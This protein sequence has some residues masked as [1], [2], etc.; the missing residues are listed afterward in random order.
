MRGDAAEKREKTDIAS[1]IRYDKDIAPEPSLATDTYVMIRNEM[2][3][4]FESEWIGP[5]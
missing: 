2:A 1:K 4:K 5:C 3:K